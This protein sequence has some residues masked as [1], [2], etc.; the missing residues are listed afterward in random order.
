MS[1]LATMRAT[2]ARFVQSRQTLQASRVKLAD[3]LRTKGEAIAAEYARLSKLHVRVQGPAS[4]LDARKIAHDGEAIQFLQAAFTADAKEVENLQAMITALFSL[5]EAMQAEIDRLKEEAA[6][7]PPE[8]ES[9][10][11]ALRS[12]TWNYLG[13]R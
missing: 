7:P 2:H 12:P 13:R 4:G 3:A 11:E 1:A 10:A 9:D 8:P 6:P 5:C